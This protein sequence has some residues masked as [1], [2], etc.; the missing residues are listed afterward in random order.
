MLLI[1]H[2][3]HL[4]TALGHLPRSDPRATTNVENVQACLRRAEQLI[5][6]RVRICRPAPVVPLGL[7]VEQPR[8][9]LSQKARCQTLASIT[10]TQDASLPHITGTTPHR[11]AVYTR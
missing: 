5:D 7:L 2:A 8:T 9:F 6:R 11:P 1:W 3:E 10:A 4:G